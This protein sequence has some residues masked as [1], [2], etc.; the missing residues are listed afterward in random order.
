MKLFVNTL[1]IIGIA[2]AFTAVWIFPHFPKTA[3]VLIFPALIIDLLD[4][5]IARRFNATSTLGKWLDSLSDIPLYLLF[6]LQYWITENNIPLFIAVIVTICGIF[7]LIRFSIQGFLQKNGEL[8]YRGLPVYYLQILLVLTI[9]IP[10]SSIWLSIALI[11][12]SIMMI[13]PI[14]IPKTSIKVFLIGLLV[15]FFILIYYLF[16]I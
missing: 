1:T 12:V 15:Y 2:L 3:F 10:I 6:P 11:S 4:G 7:R 9:I 5:Y 8:T 16:A 14:K 13:S